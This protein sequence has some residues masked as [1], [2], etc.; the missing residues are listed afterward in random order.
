MC[1]RWRRPWFGSTDWYGGEGR[2][3]SPQRSVLLQVP[4]STGPAGGTGTGVERRG[5]RRRYKGKPRRVRGV[6]DFGRDHE[7]RKDEGEVSQRRWRDWVPDRKARVDGRT[8]GKLLFL[9]RTG[10]SGVEQTI[11]DEP[12]FIVF[13]G[14]L[15]PKSFRVSR[16]SVILA[17]RLSGF[18]YT[19]WSRSVDV[20]WR[21]QRDPVSDLSPVDEGVTPLVPP[22]LLP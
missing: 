12:T 15:S 21:R 11:P 18:D 10:V 14:S 20:T 2:R 3:T 13:G 5:W 17:L 16:G 8:F 19:G 6:G 1:R 22:F 4:G 9:G 7:T